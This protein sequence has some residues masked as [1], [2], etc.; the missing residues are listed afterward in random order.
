MA[1]ATDLANK[2]Y[3]FFATGDIPQLLEHLSDDVVWTGNAS[4]KDALKVI[5]FAGT[6]H[7]NDCTAKRN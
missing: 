3:G 1:P 6:A 2:L 7:G 5:P 4:S